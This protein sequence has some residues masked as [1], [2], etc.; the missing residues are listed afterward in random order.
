MFKD[1]LI[2]AVMGQLQVGKENAISFSDLVKKADLSSGK[3]ANALYYA[4]L[5]FCIIKDEAGYYLPENVNDAKKFYFRECN[6]EKD[7]IKKLKG[8]R[9]YIIWQEK[10]A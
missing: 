6:F 7:K 2:A 8:T 3:L 5:E 9:D 10:L 4:N 1:D